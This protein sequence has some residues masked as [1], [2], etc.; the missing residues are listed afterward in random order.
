MQGIHY[1]RKQL[2]TRGIIDQLMFY[3]HLL[4]Y[5]ELL[6]Y[7]Q[8]ILFAERNVHNRPKLCT[9]SIFDIHNVNRKEC[10]D[11]C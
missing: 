7:E 5:F 11:G 3:H 10:G 2:L 8:A 6:T 4:R 9:R 1:G